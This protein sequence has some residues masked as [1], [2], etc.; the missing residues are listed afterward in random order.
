MISYRGYKR[1]NGAVG[2]RNVVLIISGD[3]C[4][5]PWSREIAAPFDSC[6]ALLHKHGVGNYAPDRELFFRLL[7]GITVHPN[8]AG[9]VLVSSGNE[10]HSPGELTQ[11]AKDAGIPFHIVSARKEKSASAVL[12]KGKRYAGRLVRE[13]SAARR[14]IAGIDTLRIGLN[15]AGTDLD[16]AKTSHLI[17]AEIVDRITSE[18]GTVVASE[19]PDLIG[20]EEALF[21]RCESPSVRAA[22]AVFMENRK[23]LLAATGE[24]ID[25]IEMVTFNVEGGLTTLEKKARV[26]I[27]KTGS[28]VIREAVPY[29]QAPSEKGLVFMDG[30]AMTDFV[31]TGFMGAGVQLMINTCGS[32]QGNKMPFTVG[33]DMPSPILPIIKMT[34]S[35]AY[36]RQRINRI[37]FDAATLLDGRE[38][39]HHA[40]R[41]L[42]RMIIET[43]S[44]KT[45]RTEIGGDY[46]L[47]IPVRFPQS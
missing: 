12:R 28:G 5:N 23:R 27:L 1:R 32:G 11:R 40:S 16:S 6:H 2:I 46:L 44:G 10:D 8:V 17:L 31:M 33:A 42:E 25:D 3:L 14:T 19:L 35:T 37:D 21:E 20:I 15:C 4:C 13:A 30:P 18:G 34:G 41:R 29:G 26:S 24:K 22:L 38:D 47:N 39:V 36:Y 43:A 9:F 45:T 7:T